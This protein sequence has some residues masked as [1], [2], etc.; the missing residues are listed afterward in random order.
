MSNLTL[1]EAK[2]LYNWL[3]KNIVYIDGQ[4]FLY[5]A[6]EILMKHELITY[7]SMIFSGRSH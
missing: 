2:I 6:S 7:R 4:N 1:D 3:M 5:K